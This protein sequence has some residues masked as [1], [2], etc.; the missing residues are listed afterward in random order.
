MNSLV[1]LNAIPGWDP[2]NVPSAFTYALWTLIIPFA[3]L[4]VVWGLVLGTRSRQLVS[5]INQAAGLDDGGQRA[6]L[7]SRG[8]QPRHALE[9]E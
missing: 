8:A 7:A 9:T 5:E 4:A 6:M 2:A 3:I 1:L